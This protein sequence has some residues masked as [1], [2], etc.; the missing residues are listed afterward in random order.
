MWIV[1]SGY[2]VVGI[3]I[4]SILCFPLGYGAAGLW[5]W[6]RH[7]A[8]PGHGDYFLCPGAGWREAAAWPPPGV[9]LRRYPDA[10]ATVAARRSR[11]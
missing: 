9:A 2:W 11:G 5:Q 10:T 6:R 1:L 7:S 4:G 3:G 8:E